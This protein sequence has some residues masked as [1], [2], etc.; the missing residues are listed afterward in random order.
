MPAPVF[1]EATSEADGLSPAAAADQTM[2]EASVDTLTSDED[3]TPEEPPSGTGMAEGPAPEEVH[4]EHTD[5]E[6]T[7]YQAL[8]SGAY[9]RDLVSM[10]PKAHS[11]YAWVRAK[12]PVS[13]QSAQFDTV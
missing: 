12:Q 4:D 11:V 2:P 10:E 6:L 8:L 3:S 9:L 1:D 5:Q 13:P 7:A